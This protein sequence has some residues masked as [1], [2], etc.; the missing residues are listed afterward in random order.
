MI[1]K[2]SLLS[3]DTLFHFTSSMDNL[4]SI[5]KNDFYPKY[6]FCEVGIRNNNKEPNSVIPIVCFCDLPISQV[7]NH[8]NVYGDYGIGLSKE[9]GKTKMVTPVLYYHENSPIEEYIDKIFL[10]V[11][12][13]LPED[14]FDT[15]QSIDNAWKIWESLSNLYFKLYEGRMFRKSKDKFKFTDV[16]RFYD[17]REWRYVPSLDILIENNIELELKKNDFD[18]PVI[19]DENQ[20]KLE[21]YCTL[22]FTPKDI[23][24][25]IV[26]NENE[27][28]DFM[29]NIDKIKG[30]YPYDDVKLLKSKIITKNQIFTDF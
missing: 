27:I 22:S 1:N 20:E 9:W 11:A 30:K 28:L 25:L 14:I 6:S 13:E 3:A 5:L 12:G 17:E 4:L 21:K 8:I 24:Y 16:I 26:E 29:D 23:K 15:D 2:S 10:T 19:L 7:K 18:N